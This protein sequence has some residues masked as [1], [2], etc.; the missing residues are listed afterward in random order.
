VDD[1]AAQV[2]LEEHLATRPAA[3][4]AES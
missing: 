3:P 4:S 2:L 1:I